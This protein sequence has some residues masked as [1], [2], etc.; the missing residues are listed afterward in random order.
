MPK[1]SYR[2]FLT[3]GRQESGTIE[4]SD[5]S[6]ARSK[7]RLMGLKVSSI[8]PARAAD[9]WKTK[10][11]TLELHAKPDYARFFSDLAIL[12]NA[13]LSFDQSLKAVSSSSAPATRRVADGMLRLISEGKSPSD[14]VGSLDNLRP[15]IPAL[16]RSGEQSGRLPFVLQ[17]IAVDLVKQKAQRKAVVDAAIY[18][19]FLLFM[20]VC[21]ILVIT[22]VLVPSIAPVFEGAGRSPPMMISVLSTIREWLSAPGFLLVVL[23]STLVGMAMFAW[24]RSALARQMSA[25]TMRLPLIGTITRDI[26]LGRYLQ[27][28]SLL[29]ANGVTMTTAL[30]LSADCC[31][32]TSFKP[33][34]N[35][36]VNLVSAGTRLSEAMRQSMLFPQ[37]VVSLAAVG[38]EVNNL[39][40]VLNNAAVM[41]QEDGQ[42]LL[43][44]ALTLMTPIITIVLG[45]L[46]GSLVISVMTALLS[47]NDL[48]QQ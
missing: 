39:P 32:V 24:Q 12:M 7:L 22:F 25:I 4:A 6:D 30:K 33:N 15:D 17:T 1:F 34:L 16:V 38:D 8:L 43:D 9:H 5:L 40:V 2:A 27:S 21:A 13:G 31:S 35:K 41:L 36:A 11:L 18:P 26:A 47:I 10:F 20:M 29:L 46:V 28:L 45:A 23:G 19:C 37:S 3:S 14:A 42:R 44:R 48:S